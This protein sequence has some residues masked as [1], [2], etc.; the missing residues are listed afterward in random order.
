MSSKAL[1]SYV[2]G[3]AVIETEWVRYPAEVPREAWPLDDED[4]D[5][6]LGLLEPN[7]PNPSLRERVPNPNL[8]LLATVPSVWVSLSVSAAS[9]IAARPGADRQDARRQ[10][11]CVGSR[12]RL[13]QRGLW[14]RTRT[15]S[16]YADGRNREQEHSDSHGERHRQ[17][18]QSAAPLLTVS[19][20]PML[21]LRLGS[22]IT[23]ARGC[24]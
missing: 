4:V 7:V 12:L 9:S 24:L 16:P 18:H 6:K 21:R 17:R 11:R 1:H 15:A 23:G 2:S 8:R 3:A 20:N 19:C 10:R 5:V 13:S 22:C 14:S